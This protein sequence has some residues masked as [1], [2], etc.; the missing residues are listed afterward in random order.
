MIILIL[1]LKKII[2]FNFRPLKKIHL[3]WI[4]WLFLDSKRK[5]GNIFAT[6]FKYKSTAL[7]LSHVII[8]LYLNSD[9]NENATVPR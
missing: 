9:E 2:Q 8:I 1:S 5:K 6:Q 7:H 4:Q 3:L